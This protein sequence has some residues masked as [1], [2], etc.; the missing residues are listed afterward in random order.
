MRPLSAAARPHGTAVGDFNGDG[1]ADLAI[2]VPR[3]DSFQGQ[4]QRRGRPHPVWLEPGAA[5]HRGGRPGVAALVAGKRR[6]GRWAGDVR[7]IRTRGGEPVSS[8]W[9]S[10]RDGVE[11][12]DVLRPTVGEVEVP[13]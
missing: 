12:G 2:G 8:G 7:W 9:R 6:R 4:Y 1:F 13:R 10:Y 11:F 5:G 3:E